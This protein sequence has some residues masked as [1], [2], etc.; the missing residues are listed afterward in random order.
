MLKDTYHSFFRYLIL[1]TIL[2]VG[3]LFFLLSSHR[4]QLQLKILLFVLAF[5]FL[6]GVIHHYLE[7]TL[8]FGVL[9]EYL[10][11]AGVVFLIILTLLRFA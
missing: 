5:Y 11:V 2:G 9:L 1:F 7:K 4:P 8:T 6:W 3:F 10:L